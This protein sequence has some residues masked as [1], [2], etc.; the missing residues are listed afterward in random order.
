MSER[1]DRKGI[2]CLGIERIRLAIMIIA[3]MEAEVEVL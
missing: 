2:I 3:K 1:D